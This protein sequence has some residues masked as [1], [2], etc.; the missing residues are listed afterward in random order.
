MI[1]NK[2]KK[3]LFL[4]LVIGS[5]AVMAAGEYRSCVGMVNVIEE[6]NKSETEQIIRFM[7]SS[8]KGASANKKREN[9]KNEIVNCLNDQWA[10][11]RGLR[12]STS[13]LD[14]GRCYD[15]RHISGKIEER[16]EGKEVDI[17][18]R[19]HSIACDIWKE[20]IESTNGYADFIVE[21]KS[22]GDKGCGWSKQRNYDISS[23]MC[24]Q[25]W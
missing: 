19:I 21:H 5:P 13:I 18:N 14:I 2:L 11:R 24:K 20:K 6:S 22:G 23:E 3:G 7:M 15:P 17:K 12:G 1:R 8:N 16:F 4:A 9:A 25:Y 10:D